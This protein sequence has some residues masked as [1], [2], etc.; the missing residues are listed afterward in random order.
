MALQTT[1]A[2][3]QWL[4]SD[5]VGTPTDMIATIAQQEYGVFCDVRSEIL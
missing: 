5:H 3:K 1:V 2:A 4:R